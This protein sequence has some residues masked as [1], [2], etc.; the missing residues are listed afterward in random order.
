MSGAGMAAAQILPG[1][2][3]RRVGRCR[4]RGSPKRTWTETSRVV[5]PRAALTERARGWACER[6]G[7]DEQ[8]V[9]ALACELG[10]G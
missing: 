7:R 8:T 10:T 1:G 3:H 4:E 9:A 6:V 2:R 5:A